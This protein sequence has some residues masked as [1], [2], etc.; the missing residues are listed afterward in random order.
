MG[1]TIRSSYQADY[2]DPIIQPTRVVRIFES[3]KM[4]IFTLTCDILFKR[5]RPAKSVGN[6]VGADEKA[7]PVS[8]RS[9]THH[10]SQ[11]VVV[12]PAPIL[13]SFST[14]KRSLFDFSAVVEKS[15]VLGVAAK[16][17]A[18]ALV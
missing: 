1:I 3:A 8:P 9:R 13:T 15:G 11:A 4:Y 10:C 6:I 5:R 12:L 7:L 18:T 14:D 2:P 17:M 16:P